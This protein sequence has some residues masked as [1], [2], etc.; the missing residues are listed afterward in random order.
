MYTKMEN[1]VIKRQFGASELY[2]EY[3]QKQ[4][5]PLTQKVLAMCFGNQIMKIL[6]TRKIYFLNHLQELCN[7][8]SCYS[9]NVAVLCKGSLTCQI[10]SI[11]CTFPRLL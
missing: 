8:G 10:D 1:Q 6:R 9:W 4:K 2:M 11:Y 5:D 3:C 7:M